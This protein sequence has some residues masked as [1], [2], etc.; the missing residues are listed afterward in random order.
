LIMI[1][2]GAVFFVV[3]PAGL[4]L[5]AYALETRLIS[6]RFLQMAFAVMCLA[7]GIFLVVWTVL[8]QT[9]VGQGTPVPVAPPRR[10][11]VTG[12][13]R[14]CRNPIQLGAIIYY[15]GVGTLFGSMEIGLAMFLLGLVIGGSYHKFVEEKELRLRF[16]EEYEEYRKKT[17]FLIPKW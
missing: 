6:G 8:T 12:P 2:G 7:A 13:Y 16:G 15:L 14:L 10:L 3:A 17:P 5:A 11:I 1:A 9:T 4:F